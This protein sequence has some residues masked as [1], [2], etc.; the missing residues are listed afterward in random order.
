MGLKVADVIIS[1]AR[2][3][4]MEETLP[5]AEAVAW[6]DGRIVAVG[7]AAEVMVLKGPV[8]QVIEAGGRTLLPGF[9][10]SHN[11]CLAGQSCSTCS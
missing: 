11:I 5:R 4:T 2:A 7:T 10:E 6:T 3:L 8:T 1:G 9:V